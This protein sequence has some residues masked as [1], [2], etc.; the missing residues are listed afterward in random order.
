MEEHQRGYASPCKK[1]V[2]FLELS[3]G[4]KT[5][6]PDTPQAGSLQRGGVRPPS[7][8]PVFLGGLWCSPSL[9]GKQFSGSEVLRPSGDQG[10][11]WM[12]A[13]QSL[14]AFWT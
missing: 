7:R 10:M 12:V 13:A 14:L 2:G 1:S 5:R 3:P 8:G 4:K 6:Y 9:P 11:A